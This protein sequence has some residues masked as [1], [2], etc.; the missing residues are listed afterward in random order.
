MKR[1]ASLSV[2]TKSNES[3]ES[4]KGGLM[5]CKNDLYIYIF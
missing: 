3:Q 4:Q 1:S 2:S 5:K